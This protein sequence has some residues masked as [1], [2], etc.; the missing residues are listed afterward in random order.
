MKPEKFRDSPSGKL[1]WTPGEYWAFAPNPLPPKIK[2]TSDLV[3]SL[4]E[5]DRALGEL[6]GLSRSLLNPYLVILPFVRREAVLSSRIEGTRASLSDLY[7]Y[8]AVQLE[9]FDPPADVREVHNYVQALE[10]GLGR[11]QT[12]PVSLRLIR[13]IHER[14]ME[15]VRGERQTPGEFR[16]SQNW[17]GP[18]GST[19]NDASYVPPPVT[20][21][22]E[23]LGSLE[24]FL[25]SPSLPPLV[26][27]GLIHYQFE[28]IHPF[29][30]G[31][32]RVGRLLIPLL[33]RAWKLLPEPVLYLSAYFEEHQEGYYNLLLSVSQK[34]W[35]EDWLRFFLRGVV[36]QSRDAVVRIQRLQ[37][38]R[39]RYREQVQSAR[40]AARLLQVVDLLFARPILTIRQVAAE[41]AVNFPTARRYVDRLEADGILREV[42]GGARNR[43]YRADEI[44]AAIDE[45]LDVVYP[46][47]GGGQA[48]ASN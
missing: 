38:L 2:W 41:L 34:G 31:N 10:Y 33:L 43:V 42:T 46:S 25:H 17:I 8:E 45:P 12:L 1:V 36:I 40:A 28:S 35:W 16:H 3:E 15:G 24:K 19:L 9:F 27:L 47:S 26:R 4:S 48:D 39:E 37:G 21:M 5:A 18:P 20:E 23:A 13:D 7:A 6:A 32:G 30:D 44:L 29:L 11:L 14:L 22:L